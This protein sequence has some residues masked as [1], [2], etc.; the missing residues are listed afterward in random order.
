MSDARFEDINDIPPYPPEWTAQQRVTAYWHA[1]NFTH[2][3][4]TT[5]Q[6]HSVAKSMER[7][8]NRRH[9]NIE[10]AQEDK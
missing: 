3:P 6:W 5:D 10:K 1:L 9:R 7:E 2:L 8:A 4:T